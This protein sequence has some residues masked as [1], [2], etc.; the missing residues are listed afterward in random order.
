MVV[1]GDL[2]GD[3]TDSGDLA[4]GDFALICPLP[5]MVAP[6]PLPASLIWLTRLSKS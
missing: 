4:S 1:G 6:V 3:G 5:K 2:L